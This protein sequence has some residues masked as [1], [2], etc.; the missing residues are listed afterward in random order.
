MSDSSLMRSAKRVKDYEYHKEKM[1]LCKKE[2]V[3]IQLSVEK[4]EW[5]KDTDDEL[6][7]QELEAHYMYM[8]KILDLPITV[9][10]DLLRDAL[11]AIFGLSE[12]KVSS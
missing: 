4:S 11:S 8:A 7:E 3:G 9:A 12:L 1:L 2:A 6:D 10:F 5:L